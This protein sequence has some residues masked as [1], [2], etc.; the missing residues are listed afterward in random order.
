MSRNRAGRPSH[1]LLRLSL[2]SY[3]SPD[4]RVITNNYVADDHGFR[5]NL[6]P[7]LHK[8]NSVAVAQ[9]AAKVAAA[10]AAYRSPVYAGGYAAPTH[11]APGQGVVEQS[12]PHE[13]P[14]ARQAYVAEPTIVEKTYASPGPALVKS[15]IDTKPAYLEPVQKTYVEP[16]QKAYV[17]HAPAVHVQKTYVEPAP[18]VHVQKTYV[19]PAPAVHVQKTYV[20]PAVH[21][22]KTYVEPA[23][24]VHVQKTYV[25]PAV[26]VQKT[27]N[28]VPSAPLVKK[29][30]VHSEPAG[31]ISHTKTYAAG[32]ATVSHKAYVQEHAPAYAPAVRVEKAYGVPLVNKYD[33]PAPYAYPEPTTVVKEGYADPYSGVSIKKTVI[34]EPPKVVSL[35]KTYH[36]DPYGHQVQ[37]EKKV[38][39]PAPQVH[40]EKTYHKPARVAYEEA[41]AGPY[42]PAVSRAVVEPAVEY[43]KNYVSQG[44]AA[45]RVEIDGDKYDAAAVAARK[46][47]GDYPRRISYSAYQ[48]RYLAKRSHDGYKKSSRRH[49]SYGYGPRNYY[50]KRNYY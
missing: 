31:V 42:G 29:E 25:E 43:K 36:A 28:H 14:V 19:E 10:S 5:S 40:V 27:Y 33:A 12:F 20:E 8:D 50:T 1:H 24:A 41:Y 38:V 45:V 39:D 30:Y 16:V 18:A 9:E 49:G 48:P 13:A 15:Y 17:E 7:T 23:P 6:A 35:K 34:D 47:Y 46:F 44:P 2:L 26:H 32:P 21:V 22:Q 4:G 37:L 11:Y 3:N